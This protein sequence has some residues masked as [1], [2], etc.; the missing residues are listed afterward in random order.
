M[1]TP[2]NKLSFWSTEL[3]FKNVKNIF[4]KSNSAFFEANEKN[5]FIYPNTTAAYFLIHKNPFHIY[6]SLKRKFSSSQ[7]ALNKLFNFQ[8]ILISNQDFNCDYDI[9]DGYDK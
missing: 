7:E 2:N 4:L 8:N 9:I 5:F 6:S 3:A 1:L